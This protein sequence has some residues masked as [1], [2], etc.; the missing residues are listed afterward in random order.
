MSESENCIDL[1]DVTE[2]DPSLVYTQQHR[3]LAAEPNRD[4][5][6]STEILCAGGH[7]ML[8]SKFYIFTSTARNL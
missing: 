3:E 8:H 4:S 6:W 2:G 7:V 5:H 1:Y